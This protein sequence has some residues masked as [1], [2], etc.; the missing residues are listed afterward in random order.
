MDTIEKYKEEIGRHAKMWS[1][2]HQFTSIIAQIESNKFF[3]SEHMLRQLL[4]PCEN[5]KKTRAKR[6]IQHVVFRGLSK[7]TIRYFADNF[8]HQKITKAL[9]H[10]RKP[11]KYND[12]SRH[13]ESLSSNAEKLEL[14]ARSCKKQELRLY[15]R[16]YQPA[17]QFCVVIKLIL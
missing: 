15:K 7:L 3:L 14:L 17:P 1:C 2:K 10:L 12:V 5:A 9:G 11:L 16:F 13:K 6:R 4:S 8:T